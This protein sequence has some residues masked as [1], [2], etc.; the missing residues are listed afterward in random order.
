MKILVCSLVIIPREA[1][2]ADFRFIR[3]LSSMY[4]LRNG[5]IILLVI[6]LQNWCSNFQGFTV[7]NEDSGVFS[8][9]HS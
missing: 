5:K 9:N 7:A 8:C 1:F 4:S 3:F 6:I 2:S